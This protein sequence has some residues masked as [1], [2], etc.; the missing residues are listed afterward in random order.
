MACTYCGRI[1]I[2]CICEETSCLDLEDQLDALLAD[3]E[4][5]HD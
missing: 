5:T 1:E 3:E 2:D 4:Q